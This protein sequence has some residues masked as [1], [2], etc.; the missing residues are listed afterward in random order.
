MTTVNLENLLNKPLFR[1]EPGDYAELADEN[2]E[3]GIVNLCRKDGT[4][5]AQMP[6]QLWDD[7]QDY[8]EPRPKGCECHLETGDSPC[9]VHG[10]EE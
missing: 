3:Q 5:I 4:V 1:P 2:D 10:E 9:P 7:L 8:D 6:R